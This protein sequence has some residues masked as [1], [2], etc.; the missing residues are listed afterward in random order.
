M[1]DFYKIAIACP[2]IKLFDCE[3]N[4][5]EIYKLVCD[6]H[7]KKVQVVIF[8]ELCLTGAT[9]L[10]LFK[11]EDL[12]EMAKKSFDALRKNLS[13]KNI[14]YVVG[15]PL[16][17]KNHLFNCAVLCQKENI[18]GV[19]PKINLSDTDKRYFNSGKKEFITQIYDSLWGNN[20]WF[21]DLVFELNNKFLLK[22]NFDLNFCDFA[23][24]NLNLS[25]QPV[26]LDNNFNELIIKSACIKNKNVCAYVNSGYGES[27]TDYVFNGSG[28]VFE[29]E[30]KLIETKRYL[31]E[32]QIVFEDIDLQKIDSQRKKTGIILK[33]GN[34]IK[35]NIFEQ[36]EKNIMRIFNKNP[37]L[38]SGDTKNFLR[39]I[40]LIQRN[41]II[42]RFN[43]SNSKKIIIGVSG[44]LDSCLSLINAILSLDYLKIDRK[45]IIG[46]SMPGFGTSNRTFE[47]AKFLLENLGVSYKIISIKN[48]CHEHLKDIDHDLKNL[49]VTFENAQVRERTQILF[50]L[51]ND[52]NGIV[53]GTGDLSEMAMGFTTYNGDHISNYNPNANLPKSLIREL[54]NFII[55]ENFFSHEINFCLKNILDTPVSPELLP[56][57]KNKNIVQ[58][59]EKI[60]GPY[61]LIDFFIYYFIK[62]GFSSEKII[63]LAQRAFKDYSCEQ[64]K[65]YF[66]IFYQR[67]I[68]QQ[69]KR[70][71]SSDGPQIFSFGLSPRNSFLMPSD[72]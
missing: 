19:I 31:T 16:K 34:V 61:E 49:N 69:F 48:V 60:L 66:D 42:T 45:N 4:A 35:I 28:F 10:D 40:L 36:D 72:I 65:S 13:D 27:T 38:N 15:L 56:T 29:K 37:F 58:Q 57:D 30:K 59:T 20:F 14:I 21:G 46:V 52:L 39:E 1:F 2:A 43:K 22:V 26:C 50:D 23:D 67:F 53:L 54:I 33:L 12:I 7:E 63:F 64:I 8:P 62:Y 3:Y 70:S 68:K 17:I 71:C 5:K 51:A 41:A 47:N 55:S 44:G 24:I 18:L 9:C 11:Q 25:S 6:A 32:S